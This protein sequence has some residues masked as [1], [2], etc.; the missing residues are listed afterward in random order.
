MCLPS[1]HC[2]A[3]LQ[4]EKKTTE[5][6]LRERLVEN[7]YLTHQEPVLEED[8]SVRS[9]FFRFL[10]G[11]AS[12]HSADDASARFFITVVLVPLVGVCSFS[13]RVWHSG[14]GREARCISLHPVLLASFKYDRT[15]R[16]Y[17]SVLISWMWCCSKA[18]IVSSKQMRRPVITLLW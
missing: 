15:T 11:P 6:L 14:A 9:F 4:E 12:L 16:S 17:S 10:M 2:C 7:P 1:C 18:S 8:G 13:E 5:T 3:C